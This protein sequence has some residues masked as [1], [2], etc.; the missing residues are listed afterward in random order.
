MAKAPDKKKSDGENWNLES[1]AKAIKTMS[2]TLSIIGDTE[3]TELCT[4]RKI[5]TG[6]PTIDY[7]GGGGI[8]EGAITIFAGNPSA[9]KT[10]L[11]MQTIAAIITEW[12]ASDIHKIVLYFDTEHSWDP[13]YAKELGIDQNY[14]VIKHT[15]VIE[16]AFAEADQLISMGFVGMLVIDSLDNMIARKVEDNAYSATMGGTAGALAQHLPKLHSKIIEYKVT[17]IVIKQARVNTILPP[18]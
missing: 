1:I 8:T 15:C 4:V 13:L 10:T 7:L 12:K 2:K 9:C 5:K 14:V 17:T 3:I 6:I 16:E 18:W 11:A